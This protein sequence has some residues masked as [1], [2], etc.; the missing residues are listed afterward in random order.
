ELERFINVDPFDAPTTA[1][2]PMMMTKAM[3]KKLVDLGVPV[4]EI[5][6][7]TPEEAWTRIGSKPKRPDDIASIAQRELGLSPEDAQQFKA[8]VEELVKIKQGLWKRTREAQIA[9]RKLFGGKKQRQALEESG[10]DYSSI[11]GYDEKAERIM[12]EYPEVFTSGKEPAQQ[13]WELA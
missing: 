9:A 10:R 8:A 4:E 11:P 2:V 3:R 5:A 1:S 7:M 6:R 12:A 13:L